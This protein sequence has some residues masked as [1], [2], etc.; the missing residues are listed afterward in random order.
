MKK[1]KTL[2]LAAMAAMA[3]AAGASAEA[4]GALSAEE[5]R[6]IDVLARTASGET[7]WLSGPEQGAESRRWRYAV[8]D[9]DH[10]GQLEIFKAIQGGNNSTPWVQCEELDAG[11]ETRH[12]GIY[13][14]GGT[15]VPDILSS[16]SAG[17]A[18]MIRDAADGKYHYVFTTLKIIDEYEIWNTKYALTLSGDLLAE[19]LASMQVAKSGKDG[20]LS[21]RCYLPGWLKSEAESA[22]PPPP[23]EE[24]SKDRYRAI[25]E[26]RFP[27]S[28]K[29]V[30]VFLWLDDARVREALA[31]GSLSELLAESYVC[32]RDSGPDAAGISRPTRFS[33]FSYE[34]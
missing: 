22:A 15:D 34:Q 16:E 19:E 31:E 7:G 33:V 27:G 2:A 26:E 17:Q 9:L 25:K 18:T 29:G 13:F 11:K 1:W 20:S 32:F 21:Y 12:W 5:A 10:N 6:Q 14:A 3:L 24:I 23:P 4:A 8:T 28:E 30:A